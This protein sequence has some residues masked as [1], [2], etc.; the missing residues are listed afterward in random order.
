MKLNLQGL[1]PLVLPRDPQAPLEAA[2][3]NYVDTVA[4]THE[5]NQNLHMTSAQN[6]W[7]D[8][9]TVSADEINNLAGLGG[10]IA[11]SLNSKLNLAG[12]NMTGALYLSGNPVDPNQATTK[13]YTDTEV[14]KRVAKAGDTMTGFLTLHAN[15]TNVLHAAPKQYV[16]NLVT[17]HADNAN[18][19]VTAGQKTLLNA[20]TATAAELNFSAGLT[21]NVQ[22]QLS[23][24][25]D[26]AG[27]TMTGALVLSGA[28]VANLHAATKQY[29]DSADALKLNL[30]GGTLSGFLTLHASPTN[31]LHAAPKQYVDSAVSTHAADATIHVTSAQKTLLNGV[32]VTSAEINRLTGLTQN[33]TTL[34]VTKLDKSGGTLTGNLQ[35]APTASI[36]VSKVAETANELVNKAYVDAKLEGKEWRNPVTTINLISAV[37]NAPPT[38]PV[39]GDS[40]IVGSVPTGA[41][42][43]K[44]GQALIYKGTAWVALQGRAVQAGDRFG[45]AL[46]TATPAEG[47]LLTHAKKIVTVVNATAGAMTFEADT[48]GP[49]STTLVFDPDAP[50]FGVT[51]TVNDEGEWIPTNTSVNITA[52]DGLELT[53]SMMNVKTGAGLSIVT[54]KV[55]VNTDAASALSVN[56]SNELTVK[57][58]TTS[59][60]VNAGSLSLEATLLGKINNAVARTGTSN[61]TG[62]IAVQTGGKLTVADAPAAGADVT[63]K[64]YV[65]GKTSALQTSVGGLDTR[66]QALEADPVT[67]AYVNT[68][69]AL[70]LNL[71]G[72]TMTGALVLSSDPSSGLHAATKQYVD[73]GV[74]SHASNTALHL[75]SAQN[76][77]IDAITATAV[78]VNYLG[79]VTSSVQTQLNGK[80]NLSGGTMTGALTLSGAPVALADATTKQYVDNADALKLN[81]AGGTMTGA[82]VLSANPVTNLEAAPKQYVDTSVSS[83]A[84][85][86]SLHLTSAQNTWIDAITATAAE[87]NHLTGVTSAVQTQ[88][89]S[90]LNLTGGAM[91]GALTLS[92]TP[93]L[94]AHAV[95]KNYVDVRTT[96]K[97]PL[98]GGT[99]TGALVLSGAPVANLEAATKQYVDSKVTSAD[100]SL[101]T[102]INNRV[103]KAGD[104]MTGFLT[105]HAAPT[106][107]MHAATKKSVDDAIAAAQGVTNTAINQTNSNVSQLR[108]DVDG[109]MLDPVTKSYVNTQDAGRVS[110][111]G[112]TMTGFL[113]L[114][115][116]PQA[117]MHPA[118]RRYVD[119]VAQGLSVKPAVRLATTVN[120]VGTYNNGTQGVNAT[121]T[122]TTNGAL[123]VDGKAVVVGDR[124][125]LRMQTAALQNGDYVVQQVG[126]ASTPFILKRVVT[127][128]ESKEIPSAFFYVS[129]GDTLKG[130]GWTFIVQNPVTFAIG[131]DAITVNQ[132]SGQGSVIAGA[133][134]TLTGNT[135]D[136]KSANSSRIVVTA[137]AID[138]ATTGVTPGTYTKV[139]VDGYGRVTTGTN[140]T[141]LAG[142]GI[143]DAQPLNQ[144]L[145]NLSSLSTRGLVVLDSAGVAT[146]RKLA[147]T[148]TGLT[149]TNADGGT[150]DIQISSNATNAAT[151]GTVVARDASGNFAANV[152]TAALSGNAS[153]AT[154]LQTSRQFSITGDLTAP[155]QSF[156]GSG[157]VVLTGTLANTGVTAGAYTKVTVDAKGRVTMGSTPNT[158]AGYGII[159][160][161][162]ITLLN[163]RYDELVTRLDELHSYVMARM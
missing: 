24:K 101:T 19:H 107:N 38:T 41:W 127:A 161:A 71:A 109:L 45:V 72:G 102:Q 92:G 159:D 95:T 15:P 116:D 153:T 134:L 155:T 62:T 79:G 70:K 73:S 21:G 48:I 78:E 23:T 125:L 151:P 141:T 34:L 28:P 152:V 63:N 64:T 52:G 97:L 145:T 114:H 16:D 56:G 105:L 85:N 149:L 4:S 39:E 84:N 93:T 156:N 115:S 126:N 18:I 110:K 82:L 2:T 53:G 119:A 20:L 5:G 76:T 158:V 27:G 6:A 157:N 163:Q 99:M 91:T 7:L 55:R 140:P 57:V 50:D 9:I 47:T 36:F 113:T 121:L 77:W 135:V 143:N 104:T 66:V 26:K 1:Q 68:Q 123:T 103:A 124:I 30:A 80:L 96:D 22:T 75:T 32:T 150:G 54:D 65:D 59:I 69:D 122:A 131:V 33:V 83:H 111:A 29:V 133:G 17:N 60:V 117:P 146:T 40:Y 49:R 100:T 51:Y 12:G 106:A 108:T 43:N 8:A 35:M 136:V 118:T 89:N 147:V 112:D 81:L 67:K 98:A 162:T 46:R 3:K 11:E 87:V 88:L 138:L 120:L 37:K 58:D 13:Q 10:N 86:Q 144:T 44:A 137:D 94:D 31:A 129:D 130:T 154:T 160:A 142:Y 25:L 90:K 148:G 128:D 132:F 61:V 139:V 14:G 42:A 74:S